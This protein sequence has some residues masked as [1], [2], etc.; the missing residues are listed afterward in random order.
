M[1]IIQF[2]VA[3]ARQLSAGFLLALASSFGQTY[4]IAIFAES[5]RNEFALSHGQFGTIYMIATLASAACLIQLGRL[6]DTVAA[7]QLT[8]GIVIGLALICASVA[9][10][11][12]WFLLLLAI[13][14]LRLF[15]QGLM[16]HLSQTLM[17]RWF[18]NTR[19]R[20]LAI[21]S[22]GH[23][24]GEALAPL[25]AVLLIAA[26]GWRETWALCAALL[27]LVFMPV[28]WWLLARERTPREMENSGNTGTPGLDGR[29][30][31]RGEVIRQPLFWA[32]MPGIVSPAF[33]MTAMFFLPAHIAE[34]KGWAFGTMPSWY[35]VF[36]LSA[37]AAA[38]LSGATIDR[39]SA[40]ACLPLYQLP[41]AAGLIVLWAAEAPEM[42]PV[43]LGLMGLTAGSSSTINSALWAEYY[44]T[45]H[46]G[47][48]KALSHA[49]MVFSS[50]IGPGFAG[51]VI[52]LGAP[53]PQQTLWYAAYA[54]AV[55]LVFLWIA[56]RSTPR[57]VP[58]TC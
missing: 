41:M 43:A 53:L 54:A 40:R 13:F 49:M 3:N 38:F 42:A 19:G 27:V 29:H 34:S 48:I 6:A 58:G 35:W 28:F 26:I 12:S 30:W 39:F 2:L 25:A 47:T 36:A 18:N 11:S 14:G 37:V 33:I 20:A 1:P 16:T 10:V 5:W 15:G 17:A 9:F 32:L 56:L 52:D 55:S 22:F 21:A 23:P 44:G 50:A 8:A 7:R 24:A 31:T 51:A 4:F 46:L 45:H 57:P